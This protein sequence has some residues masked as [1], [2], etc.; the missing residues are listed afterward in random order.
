M[1]HAHAE[2]HGAHEHHVTSLAV[3]FATFAVLVALTF[4]TSALAF[5][6]LGRADI[7][8]TLGIATVKATLVALIFMHLMHDKAFNGLIL[9]STLVFVSI[10]VGFLLMDTTEYQPQ[11]EAYTTDEIQVQ[12]EL[13]AP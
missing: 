13:A 2:G 7:W 6:D 12:S 4:L 10:F 8:I 5:V 9:L 1:G 11:I 3:L